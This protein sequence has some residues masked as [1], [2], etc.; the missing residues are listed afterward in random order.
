MALCISTLLGEHLCP[1]ICL[2]RPSSNTDIA[3]R[4][5][6]GRHRKVVSDEDYEMFL[7]VG[8]RCIMMIGG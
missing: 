4:V 7:K 3:S 6:F 1:T 2:G 8:Y 5:G